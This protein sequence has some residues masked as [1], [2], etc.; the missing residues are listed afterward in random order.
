M[1]IC[2]YMSFVIISPLQKNTNRI[3]CAPYE[4]INYVRSGILLLFT[5]TVSKRH[6]HYTLILHKITTITEY[7]N[8]IEGHS[9]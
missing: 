2:L 5:Q 6:K 8:G 4:H 1:Y 3:E 7:L 9:E